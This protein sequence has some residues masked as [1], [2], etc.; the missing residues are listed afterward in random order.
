MI[1][2][3]A[4]PSADLVRALLELDRASLDDTDRLAAIGAW[5]RV[6]SMAQ[7]HQNDLLAD[8]EH[9]LPVPTTSYE[10]RSQHLLFTEELSLALGVSSAAASSRVTTA[11]TLV[12]KLPATTAAL[13]NGR[14]TGH[15]ARVAAR[16]AR[17]L[18]VDLARRVDADVMAGLEDEQW[19]TPSQLEEA[20]RRSLLTHDPA[21]SAERHRTARRERQVSFRPQPDGMASMWALLP[22]E[23]AHAVAG[24]VDARARALHAGRTG[25]DDRTLAECRADAL[26]ELVAAGA[27]SGVAAAGD[28]PVQTPRPAEVAVTVAWSTLIGLDDAPADLRGYGPIDAATA[29]RIAADPGATWRR[30]LTDP[31]SGVVLDVG[32]RRYRPPADLRRHVVHRDHTCRFPTCSR[33]SVSCDQDHRHPWGHGG[34]TAGRNL[35]ALCRRH[36]RLRHL[37]RVRHDRDPVTGDSLWRTPA[38]RTHRRPAHRPPPAPVVDP[39]DLGDPPF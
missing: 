4:A 26:V 18:S 20:F 36:H 29:R 1:D 28:I 23:D 14:I 15:H 2:L 37:T 32:R 16:T 27:G 38:R 33:P 39:P 31:V 11:V 22:V 30:L 21:G 19:R 8:A 9:A 12:E 10:G 6:L 35:D 17:H 13:R 7:A 24:A 3:D 5:E 25:C 34:G